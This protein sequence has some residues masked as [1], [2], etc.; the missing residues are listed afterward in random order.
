MGEA[1]QGNLRGRWT[2]L[3][4]AG[5]FVRRKAHAISAYDAMRY[6]LIALLLV[7]FVRLIWMILTPVSPVGDWRAGQVQTIPVTE[8]VALFTSF[9]PFDR[10]AAGTGEAAVT[11]LDLTLYGLR[12]NEA[13]GQGSAILASSD[14]IQR[15][16]VVG[17]EI[18]AG[19]TLAAVNFDHVILDRG[20][21]RENLY[22]DQSVPAETVG[23]TPPVLSGTTALPVTGTASPPQLT[24][25]NIAAAIG[26]S[27]R[28]E[29]G[30]VTGFAVSSNGDPAL[31]NAAGF[32]T[33]DIINKINGRDV[34]SQRDIDNLRDQ[35]RPGA[36]L[37]VMVERGAESI[38]IAIVIPQ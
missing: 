23:I 5:A 28:S 4:P 31:F 26:F 22:I 24:A 16:F 13:S 8:R 9:D 3:R 18:I 15:S 7:Q 25:E 30:R 14:G 35:I 37:S 27:P 34:T 33:G 11:S 12:M 17:Q 38:P 10:S 6:L 21:I 36:R 2:Q 32:R 1:G 19:V 29:N 20:G